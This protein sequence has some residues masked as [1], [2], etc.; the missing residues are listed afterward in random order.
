MEAH[1][2]VPGHPHALS[3]PAFDAGIAAS[4][5]SRPDRI[6]QLSDETSRR[7]RVH[8]RMLGL[9]DI[10]ASLFAA[11]LALTQL[12]DDS[13][14]LA[15]VLLVPPGILIAA[16]AIGLYDR[17]ELLIRKTTVEE[18]PKLFQLS[19]LY[20][21]VFWLN[22]GELM[23]GQL[24]KNQAM[25]LAGV[26]LVTAF[27]LR[28]QARAHAARQTEP[29]RILFIGDERAYQR[30][31]ATFSRH[32]LGAS[33]TGR[34]AIENALPAYLEGTGT[35]LG[36]DDVIAQAGAHRVVIGPHQL[37][38]QATFDLV[39][40][41]RDAGARVS[42]LPDM[43]EVTGSNVA[44]DDIFGTTV[45]GVRSVELGRSSRALK[46]AMDLVGATLL[47][48]LAAPLMVLIAVAVKLDSRGPLFFWQTRVGRDGRRFRICKFR[49][50][51]DGA[52]ELKDG[53][54]A[55][56]EAGELFKLEADPRIT[57][58]GA[59]LRRASLDELPQLRNVLAGQM[60][61][62][63]P[64]PLVV[65]EDTKITGAHRTR[66]RL[67]PGMTGAWQILGSA[68]VPLEEMVKLDHLYV[69]SWS[70]WSDVEILLRTVPHVVFRRGQ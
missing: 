15:A 29:E 36:L 68:R 40:A 7:D 17:D 59:L 18:L 69:S 20:A 28:C 42:L 11:Y 66:L 49:T 25:G 48:I 19:V 9:A 22:D 57:R 2:E 31:R 67:T 45:L 24:G 52:D 1:T 64:R 14:Q 39:Q 65:D 43:L 41:A 3:I 27:L 10:I 46:R 35:V 5:L 44:F 61:L 55:I 32:G 38:P 37:S 63:G 51:C 26:F 30:L 13:V 21:L 23:K 47:A 56:N 70:L 62:V 50:M 53:L 4:A 16:K 12:G 8:R 60:S 6:A 54:R 58:V 34:L 33:I